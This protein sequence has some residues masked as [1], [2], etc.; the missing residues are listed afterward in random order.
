MI[1]SILIGNSDDKLRQSSWAC[2]YEDVFNEVFKN[3][4][5][6]YFNGSSLPNSPFQN[7]CFVFSTKNIEPLK[8][9]MKELCEFYDQDSIVLIVGETEFLKFST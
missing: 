4:S 2:F 9:A 7:A 5:Q 8:K 3:A 6:I 1:Y